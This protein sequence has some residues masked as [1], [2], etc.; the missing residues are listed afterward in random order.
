VSRS[1]PH[2]WAVS[3]CR[4][5]L[6]RLGRAQLLAQQPRA[7][8]LPRFLLS[9]RWHR[10]PICQGTFFLLTSRADF[11][12]SLSP[13]GIRVQILPF[14]FLE[15]PLGYKNELVH[16]SALSHLDAKHRSRPEGAPLE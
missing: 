2:A 8:A 7:S 15:S 5:L 12:P 11:F 14:P 10:D 6:R 16:P 9:R 4:S 3:A 1:L 13:I